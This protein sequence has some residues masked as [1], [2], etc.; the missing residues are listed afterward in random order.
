MP[1]LDPLLIPPLLPLPLLVP[2]DMPLSSPP[3]GS[4]MK[5]FLLLPH[6]PEKLKRTAAARTNIAT[7][8]VVGRVIAASLC[9]TN[10][11][12]SAKPFRASH[13]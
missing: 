2:N 3:V 11:V 1:L 7:K 10:I 6:P 9:L 12:I 8:C 4:P 13:H 5:V